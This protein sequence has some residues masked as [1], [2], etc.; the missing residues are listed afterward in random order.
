MDTVANMFTTLINAQR[1]G[2]ER[3]AVPHSRFKEQL[4]HLLRDK[5]VVSRV[6]LQEGVKPKLVIT[7]LYDDGVPKVGEYRRLSKPGRRLYVTHDTLPHRGGRPGF[8]VISTSRGLMD[9][10]TAR[11]D[12]I[13]GELIC[14][15]G[16]SYV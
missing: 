3:V 7:L 12:K 6:R 2:R 5:G 8:Y 10:V 13:G 15:I 1:V 11:H 4:A 14:E 16:Y 9:E